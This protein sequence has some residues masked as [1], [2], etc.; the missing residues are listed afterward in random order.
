M[1]NV[2]IDFV[3]LHSFWRSPNRPTIIYFCFGFYFDIASIFQYL[4]GVC[5][6]QVDR[7]FEEEEEETKK[8]PI[9]FEMNLK[10]SEKPSLLCVLCLCARMFSYGR[11]VDYKIQN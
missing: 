1:R 4:F 6:L 8:K 9:E 10:G 5:F 2:V 11:T 3:H 7:M